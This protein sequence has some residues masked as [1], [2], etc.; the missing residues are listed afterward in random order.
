MVQLYAC[1]SAII[2]F[3]PCLVSE[4]NTEARLHF[5]HPRISYKVKMA[6]SKTGIKEAFDKLNYNNSEDVYPQ[7]SFF[8]GLEAPSR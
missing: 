8:R 4:Q 7:N 1:L 2:Y 5:L 3:E 6:K